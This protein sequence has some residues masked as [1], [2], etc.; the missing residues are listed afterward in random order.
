MKR[1]ETNRLVLR[2]FKLQDINDLFD[3]AKRDDVGPKA[4]WKPHKNKSESRGILKGFIDKEEVYA[5]YHKINK[6]V[7]GSIGIHNTIIGDLENV[8]EIGYV[9]NPDYHNKGFMSEA[10]KRILDYCFL[11]LSYD[12]V[13]V[14]H[15][16]DNK[17][18]EKLILKFNFKLI[19]EINYKSKDYGFIPTKIYK[20]T[21]LNYILNMED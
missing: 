13:Y 18:S 1:L 6:K 21:K 19:R 12:E 7:I 3:Y 4:G 20:L 14:G 10:L 16:F 9:L 5:I 15:F 17:P 2:K 8:I 11:E